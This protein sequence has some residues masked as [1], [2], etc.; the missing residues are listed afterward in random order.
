MPKERM[1]TFEKLRQVKEMITQP[2]FYWVRFNLS[3]QQALN[4]DP[5]AIKGINFIANLD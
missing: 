1:I 5:K 2:V 3:K 4:D